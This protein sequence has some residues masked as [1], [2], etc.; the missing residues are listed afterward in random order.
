VLDIGGG[1]DDSTSEGGDDEESPT[2]KKINREVEA[3][4]DS[5]KTKQELLLKQ[6]VESTMILDAEVADIEERDAIKIQLLEQFEENT[7]AIKQAAR[8]KE[9]DALDKAEKD[10]LKKQKKLDKD[11]SKQDKIDASIDKQNSER[12]AQFARDSM[13]LAAFVFEDNKGIAAGIALMNTAQGVTKALASQDYAGAA[14]TGVMGAGQIAAILGASKGGGGSIPSVTAPAP[15]NSSQSDF[16]PETTGLELSD[17]DGSGSSI[18]TIRFAT[19]SG[20]DI[21]NA[22]AGALNKGQEEG[23]FQ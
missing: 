3:I 11:K 5:F 7:A 9:Q 4:K 15:T 1:D 20:D 10:K 16:L 23:R 18:Q 8:D 21:I 17:S 14:I 13:A 12:E 2:I 19:D 22:I 6:F